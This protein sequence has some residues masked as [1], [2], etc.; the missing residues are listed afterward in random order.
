MVP[1]LAF[2]GKSEQ[3][4]AA[5]TGSAPRNCC[6][7][8]QSDPGLRWRLFGLR[9]R[10]GIGLWRGSGGPGAKIAD[11]DQALPQQRCRYATPDRDMAF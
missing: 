9:E 10:T 7:I 3:S 5:R 4:S 2:Q 1:E 8:R 6:A 11:K